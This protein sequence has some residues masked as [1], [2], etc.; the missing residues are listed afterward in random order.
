MTIKLKKCKCGK[1]FKQYNSLQ[2]KCPNCQF[3]EYYCRKPK[4]KPLLKLKIGAKRRS[5][6]DNKKNK[7]LAW[8]WFSQ[9]IRLRDC[10]KTTKSKNFGRCYTCD[11][12]KPFKELQA[13]HLISGRTNAVLLD[14]EIVK[15]QCH[16]CNIELGGNYTEYTI[17]MINEKGIKWVQSK[18]D[19]KHISVKKNWKEEIEIWKDKYFILLYGKNKKLPF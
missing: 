15:V 1:E 4:S 7:K 10:L 16:R 5:N 17:R 6:T 14:E 13:G 12:I 3:K 9:Y 18:Q 11:R 2:N 8:K 19:L